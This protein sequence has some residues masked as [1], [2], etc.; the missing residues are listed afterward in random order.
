MKIKEANLQW[1]VYNTMTHT[2][3]SNNQHIRFQVYWKYCHFYFRIGNS[4]NLTNWEPFQ[5]LLK[6][7]KCLL[8]YFG[9]AAQLSD[10]TGLWWHFSRQHGVSAPVLYSRT[11]I[12]FNLFY[13]LKLPNEHLHQWKFFPTQKL[14]FT[15]Q[16]SS[17][18][19]SNGT[20][21]VLPCISACKLFSFSIWTLE[22][23]EC[24]EMD[25]CH[26]ALGGTVPWKI[27]IC[28]EISQFVTFQPFTL[29]YYYF[30]T[31]LISPK[32]HFEVK[33]K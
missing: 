11:G 4:W 25:S 13:K 16:L 24:E 1:S 12:S 30:I 2:K 32:C 18:D 23:L 28:Q 29:F 9:G 17:Q 3:R 10:T 19:L 26:K 21:T 15:F 31:M 33:G 20:K 27:L 22:L 7:W 5:S 6:L 14:P 8:L